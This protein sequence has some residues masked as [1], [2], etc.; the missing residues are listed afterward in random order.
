MRASLGVVLAASL[1]L[2]CGEDIVAYPFDDSGFAPTTSAPA[3]PV[4]QTLTACPDGDPQEGSACATSGLVC[5]R[6]EELDAR[7]SPTVECDGRRWWH[8]AAS[9]EDACPAA[10]ADVVPGALCV[11]RDDGGSPVESLCSYAREI[12]GCTRAEGDAWRWRCVPADPG[13]PAVR[14]RFGSPCTTAQI[15]DY[16]ACVF[17]SGVSLRC[18]VSDANTTILQ[19]SPTSYFTPGVW[20]VTELACSSTETT[21]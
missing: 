12:C 14:P 13:C 21:P 3:R 19:P 20:L 5:E 9:C 7:C 11:P 8:R 18:V 1:L 4:P 2:A 10:R 17:S 15:C 6:G 16:G